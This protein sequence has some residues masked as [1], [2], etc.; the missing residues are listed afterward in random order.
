MVFTIHE[1]GTFI[2]IDSNIFA[3][4][5][6]STAHGEWASVGPASVTAAFTLLQSAPNKIFLGGFKNLFEANLVDANRM[7][8][9]ITAFLY[10]YTDANGKVITDTD[11]FPVPNPLSPPEECSPAVGCVPLGSFSFKVSRVSAP[12]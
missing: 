12:R 8:G 9:K 11:G 3:G 5:N 4:G 7:E 1:D 6:H 2:G 10:L